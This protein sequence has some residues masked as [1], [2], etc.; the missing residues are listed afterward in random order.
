LNGTQTTLRRDEFAPH[1]KEQRR[2]NCW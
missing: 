1:S 2:H